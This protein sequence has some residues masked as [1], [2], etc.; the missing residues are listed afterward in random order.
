MRVYGHIHARR[1]RMRYIIEY[2]LEYDHMEPGCAC[3]QQALRCHDCN[4]EF[5]VENKRVGDQGL[6]LIVTK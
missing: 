2:R 1:R 5:Q 3:S 6:A 4:T